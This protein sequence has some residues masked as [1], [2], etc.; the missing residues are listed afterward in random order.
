ML[1]KQ[2]AE[3]DAI[4]REIVA[5]FERHARRGEI[6]IDLVH[7][8]LGK[9]GQ[10]NF[11]SLLLM[12]VRQTLPIAAANGKTGGNESRRSHYTALF[13]IPVK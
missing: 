9:A 7:L 3:I 12:L 8:L 10:I 5:L 4:D 1:E 2:R 11:H 13:S 6:D